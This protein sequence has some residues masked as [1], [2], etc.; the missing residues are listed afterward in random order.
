MA[1][2]ALLG[3]LAALVLTGVGQVESGAA[4]TAVARLAGIIAVVGGLV[5]GAAGLR[6]L[7]ANLTPF[8]EPIEHAPLVEDGIYARVRHPLYG[9]LVLGSVGISLLVMNPVAL[10]VA[11]LLSG[12]LY[13]K[14]EHEER[15]LVAHYPG[16]GEYRSRVNKR[17]VPWLL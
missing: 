5:I 14:S 7:G 10:A 11:L 6:E 3:A 17:F 2:A 8:P 13:A 16:Y 9:A 15:R 12:F 1:Q 4:L